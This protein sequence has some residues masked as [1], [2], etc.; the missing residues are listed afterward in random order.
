MPTRTHGASLLIVGCTSAAG[1]DLVTIVPNDHLGHG[2]VSPL[3]AAIIE[4]G[5]Y[6]RAQVEPSRRRQWSFASSTV[7]WRHGSPSP[8]QQT[9]R[10]KKADVDHIHVRTCSIEEASGQRA[11]LDHPREN[12]RAVGGDPPLRIDVAR[13]YLSRSPLSLKRAQNSSRS[14]R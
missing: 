11:S 7:R 14:Q 8:H 9:I 1:G 12:A 3:P 2:V 4:S 5:H 13:S 10:A 6:R